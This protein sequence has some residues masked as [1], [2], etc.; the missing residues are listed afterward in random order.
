[1]NFVR[2]LSGAFGVNIIAVVLA[3]RTQAFNAQIIS[4]LDPTS[5]VS[6]RYIEQ[7]SSMTIPLNLSEGE[8]YGVGVAHLAEAINTQAAVMA[9]S[10]AWNG[11]AV[12]FSL[13]LIG[14]LMMYFGGKSP[15]ATAAA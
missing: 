7:L 4:S 13:S 12:A 10:V 9:Y 14:G 11:F 2:Q 3:D 15:R 8:S 5:D 6:A 1:M